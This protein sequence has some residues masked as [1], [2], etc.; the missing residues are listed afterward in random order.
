[1]GPSLWKATGSR[2]LHCVNQARIKCKSSRFSAA[3]PRERTG[4][5]LYTWFI[6][7]S[8]FWWLCD[9][10]LLTRH[11]PSLLYKSL[12]LSKT[13]LS[14]FPHN[15]VI[16]TMPAFR[17]KNNLAVDATASDTTSAKS[18]YFDASQHRATVHG[19]KDQSIE[20]SIKQSKSAFQ[21]G[22]S[23]PSRDD[24]REAYRAPSGKVNISC[25]YNPCAYI[26]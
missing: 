19:E 25:R 21:L 8:R 10:S 13:E 17:S 15:Q 18:K 1:M 14:F 20:C 5:E 11:L 16:K 3:M 23:F 2:G 4:P 6:S 7:E 9:D 26:H 12:T 22:I 24:E